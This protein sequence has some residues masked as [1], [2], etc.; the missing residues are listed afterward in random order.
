MKYMLVCRGHPFMNG[1]KVTNDDGVVKF[2]WKFTAG[3]YRRLLTLGD[4]LFMTDPVSYVIE[5]YKE[6]EE[7]GTG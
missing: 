5:A 6:K 4:G 7:D 1:W 3:W 2:R